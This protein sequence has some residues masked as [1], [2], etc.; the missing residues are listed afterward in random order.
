MR[1]SL[2]QVNNGLFCAIVAINVYIIA[3]PLWPQV[4]FWW[5]S[6]HSHRQAQLTKVI[7]KVPAKS[8]TP[9]KSQPNSLIIPSI[10][11]EQPALEG[12]EKDWFALLKEGI[13]RWP[14][15]STPDKGGNTVFLSHRFSYTGPHG[16][17]YYLNKV[18]IG[19]E[20]GVLWNNKMYR[21]RVVSSSEVPPTDTAIEADTPGAQITLFTCTP[22]WHPV[23]R[24]VVVAKLEATL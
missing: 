3:A 22:L 7:H 5:Q 18:R 17:F 4:G 10:M 9:A 23:N 21:Y 12:P 6:H 2:R 16:A 13:W 8:G 1:V 14:A 24:L 19:D 11:L 20:I 15:S